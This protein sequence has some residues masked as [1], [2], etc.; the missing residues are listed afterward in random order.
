[1]PIL[2]LNGVE[3]AGDNKENLRMK[4]RALNVD[5]NNASSNSLSLMSP[6]DASNLDISSKCVLSGLSTNL[7]WKRLQIDT[8]LLLIVTN[9]ADEL[10]KGTKTDD[11]KRPWNL[12]T[13]WF[14]FAIISYEA[15]FNSKLR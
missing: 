11:I 6:H 10:L 1:M 9:T 5:L 7:A 2:K 14:F 8:D 13:R 3:M 4:F 12:K 15:Y